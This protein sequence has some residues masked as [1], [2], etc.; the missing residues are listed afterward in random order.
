MSQ[1]RILGKN[2]SKITNETNTEIGADTE[3]Q[4]LL[5]VVIC[6]IVAYVCLMLSAALIGKSVFG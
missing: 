6:C 1:Y 2:M 3:K 4:E 5:P